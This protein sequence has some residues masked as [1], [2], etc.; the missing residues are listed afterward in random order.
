[1]DTPL[2]KLRAVEA[3][4]ITGDSTPLVCLR[5]PQHYATTP[6]LVPYSAYYILTLLDGRRSAADVQR[7]FTRQYGTSLDGGELHELLTT[8]DT[9]HF[10]QSGGFDAHRSAIDHEF[11]AA[12]LRMPAHAGA[13]YPDEAGALR[14]HLDAFFDEIS[15]P[16]PGLPLAG[17]VAPHI[18]L[19][20]GGRAYG[21]AY[22]TLAAAAP[23][24]RYVVLGTSH[25]GGTTRFAATRKDFATP[26]GTV[27]TD[28]AFL[29]R[30]GARTPQNLYADEILHRT[31]HAVEF[32][33]VMLQHV[34]GGTRPFSIVPLLVTSFH[35][36]I[37]AGT[38][39]TADLDVAAFLA[40]LRA[41]LAED[42]VPTV[43]VAGVDFAHVGAKFGD[44]DGL[45][46]ELLAATHAK[47]RT[48][49]AAL[50]AGDP[51][52]FFT[53]LAADGDRTRICGAAPLLVFLELLRGTPGRLLCHE[54][55]RDDGTRS[56]VTYASLAFDA[57]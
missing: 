56:A 47:D 51:S 54:T 9:H 4:P 21:H 22:A 33:V 28:R 17:L 5:D 49:L 35:D 2:P 39:P 38:P 24:V 44:R 27:P 12:T 34:L 1:M 36:L 37:A 25:A 57:A 55:N 41:T 7:A 6:L 18:D 26:L 43:L 40:A 32:Q 29:D 46:S 19:R 48:L 52:G 8:L 3:F 23:A 10:L 31:E 16:A 11:R 53:A 30:L 50:E 42:D 14:L 45:T 20:I 13:S 15:P